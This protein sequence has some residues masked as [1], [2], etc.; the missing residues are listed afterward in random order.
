MG[1]LNPKHQ[2]LLEKVKNDTMG[3]EEAVVVFFRGRYFDQ[4]AALAISGA[5]SIRERFARRMQEKCAIE[6]DSSQAASWKDIA[7]KWQTAFTNVYEQV[8]F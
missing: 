4:D 7:D 5:L 2:E 1:K 6:N 8:K 3:C